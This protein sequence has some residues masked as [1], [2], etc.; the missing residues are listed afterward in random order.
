M[1]PFRHS[2]WKRRWFHKNRLLNP[3]LRHLKNYQHVFIANAATLT[4]ALWYYAA[5][6]EA[7]RLRCKRTATDGPEFPFLL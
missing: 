7:P 3:L 5:E 4:R 6:E 1:T 2:G